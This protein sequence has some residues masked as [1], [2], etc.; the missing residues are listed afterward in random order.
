[1]TFAVGLGTS[2]TMVYSSL[3]RTSAVPVQ[4]ML[5]GTH[6]PGAVLVK[7]GPAAA[8]SPAVQESEVTAAL[9]AQPGTARYVG[10][11]QDQISVLGLSSQLQLVAFAG[12]ASWTGYTMI[13]GHWY[14]GSSQVDVNTAFL[15]DTGLAVGS[16]YR[17]GHT[18]VTIAGEVFDPSGGNPEMIGALS[19]LS[20]ADPGLTVGQYDVG[21]TSGTSVTSYVNDL[22]A[23][24]SGDAA[25]AAATATTSSMYIAL[26]GLITTMTLLLGAVAGLGVLNTVLLQTR[27]RVHDLGVFKAVGMTP[28][29][30]IA[31]VVCSV[32]GVGLLAGLIAAPTGVALHRYVLPAMASGAQT[33][34]PASFVN[35]YHPVELV[36]LVLAG[37]AIAVAGALGPASWAAKTRTASAL[38]TE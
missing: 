37:L 38:R 7:N 26:I 4:V 31:M 21:L 29:Q 10:E 2:L 11:A 17:I 19:T 27:E 33:G 36:L 6:G 9:R 3:H 1:V 5:A 12:D 35:V 34:I 32:A 20:A 25:L 28:R 8:P 15:T 24:V 13:S 18:T 16:A 30:T 23:R 14:S 22:G